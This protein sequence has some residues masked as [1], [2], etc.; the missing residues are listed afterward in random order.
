MAA[1][2]ITEPPARAEPNS[3]AKRPVLGRSS[4]AP[5][6]GCSVPA[7]EATTSASWLAGTVVSDQAWS[8][9]GKGCPGF[10][11]SGPELVDRAV[12]QVVQL[13]RRM[14]AEHDQGHQGQTHG[15]DY[16]FARLA[17]GRGGPRARVR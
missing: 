15:Q 5:A 10:I 11:L 12:E 6:G 1:R 16:Q 2:S 14:D 17:L 7:R 13:V 9:F 8:P 4:A 3:P